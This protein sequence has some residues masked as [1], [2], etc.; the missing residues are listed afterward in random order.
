MIKDNP[1]DSDR[2]PLVSIIVPCYNEQATIRVLLE[3][4]YAQT[5]PRQALEVVIA[6]GMSTDGTREEI[7]AFMISHPDLDVRVIDNLAGTIPA[8]LNRAIE[9]AEGTYIVRLDAHSKPYPDYVECCV[10]DLEAGHGDN[11]G[12]VWIIQPGGESW[13]ARSIAVAAAH[14]FGVGDARYRIGGEAQAVDTV[15]FGSYAQA[16]VERIGAYD[17]SLLSNEDYEFN[18]RVRE[19]GGVVWINPAIKT[20]YFARRTMGALARQYWRYGYW[21]M[22]MLRRYPDTFRWRQLA[23]AFVLSFLILGLLGIWFPLARWFLVL[24][25]SLYFLVLLTAGIQRAFQEQDFALSFGVP[26]A[27]ATMH[28]SW[29]SAF[30]WSLVSLIFRK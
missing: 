16:L 12:G 10:S 14:P 13:Q 5:T 24:E 19:S 3:A 29:G 21:K 9:E 26:L 4:I 18:V 8:G 25:L 28:F 7:L 20:V 30:L 15:P 17:E 27:I 2:A 1:L 22:R 11:V 6:D 23:G